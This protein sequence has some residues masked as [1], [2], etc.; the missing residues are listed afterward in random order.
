ML[1]RNALADGQPQARPVYFGR[2]KRLEHS[3]QIF[4]RNAH[5]GV[6][7][8]DPQLPPAAFALHHFRVDRQH[9]V[10]AH[11]FERVEQ[12]IHERLLQLRVVAATA[13][14]D[15]FLGR[16]KSAGGRTGG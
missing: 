7:N 12:E 13:L 10:R 8:V 4:R 5:A 14:L 9:A 15:R 2:E 6:L 11:R 3:P 16:L 1:P